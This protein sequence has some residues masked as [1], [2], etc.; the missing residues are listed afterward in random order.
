[1]P[2]GL[3]E[4]PEHEGHWCVDCKFSDK[5][6]SESPCN[7]CYDDKNFIKCNFTHYSGEDES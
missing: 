4:T 3:I 2:C 1:M 7:E 5:Q 6:K